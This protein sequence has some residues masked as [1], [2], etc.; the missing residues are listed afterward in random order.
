MERRCV[1]NKT[2]SEQFLQFFCKVQINNNT[3]QQYG[4]TNNIRPV[5]TNTS[6]EI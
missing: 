6:T 5:S 2:A 3:S 1:K 4:P